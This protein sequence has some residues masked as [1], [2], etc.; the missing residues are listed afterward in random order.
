MPEQNVNGHKT[1][2]SRVIM[3]GA[4]FVFERALNPPYLGT[5][6]HPEIAACYS[7]FCLIV[8]HVLFLVFDLSFEPL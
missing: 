5:E 2:Q 3:T 8:S 7:L 6:P 1:L 4:S